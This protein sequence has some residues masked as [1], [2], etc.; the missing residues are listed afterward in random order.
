MDSFA[1]RP[2]GAFVEPSL[3][4]WQLRVL[5]LM[6]DA[7]AAGVLRWVC[8]PTDPDWFDTA[9]GPIQSFIRFKWPSY[10][11]DVSSARDFVEVDGAGRFMIGTPGWSLALE[12]LGAGLDD[13]GKHVAA[14]RRQ[15]EEQARLLTDAIEQRQAETPPPA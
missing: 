7:T 6:R 9:P 13:W 11:G 12:I 1:R 2:R 10:N 4:E 8:S 3:D 5:R 15:Y 14:L